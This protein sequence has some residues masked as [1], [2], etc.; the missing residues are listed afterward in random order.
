MLIELCISNERRH[1]AGPKPFAK[2]HSGANKPSEGSCRPVDPLCDPSHT[3]TSE[4]DCLMS[5][6]PT[7]PSATLATMLKTPPL[8]PR[9][10]LPSLRVT[11]VM[12]SQSGQNRLT[13]LRCRPIT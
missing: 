4:R 13:G 5:F 9:N 6:L 2:E 11:D 8:T 7:S 1:A 3:L 10:R 12:D